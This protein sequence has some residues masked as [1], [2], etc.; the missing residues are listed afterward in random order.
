M[1]G[2]CSVNE[3]SD[4]E[5]P[6]FS[7]QVLNYKF[8]E[9][10]SDI[11]SQSL[12]D[13]ASE[14][15]S[16]GEI[17][18]SLQ[19]MLHNTYNID[20]KANKAP[21]ATKPTSATEGPNFEEYSRGVKAS[22]VDIENNQQL[23]LNSTEQTHLSS[24]HGSISKSLDEYSHFSWWLRRCSIFFIFLAFAA[25]IA[26]PL[27]LRFLVPKQEDSSDIITPPDDPLPVS[28]QAPSATPALLP[29][30][31]PQEDNVSG[32][33]EEPTSIGSESEEPQNSWDDFRWNR[34]EMGETIWRSDL[35]GGSPIW[36]FA[37]AEGD[38][39][40]VSS[41][42]E[43]D[44]VNAA[45]GIYHSYILRAIDDYRASSAVVALNLSTVP[46]ESLCEPVP[47]KI[48]IC[49]GTFGNTDWYGQTILLMKDYSVVAAAIQI[50]T[51]KELSSEILQHTLC[52]QLG[53]ALGLQHSDR[54]SCLQ[55]IGGAVV[56][57]T[58]IS[59]QLQHPSQEDL[60]SLV[61]LYGP[62]IQRR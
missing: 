6:H 12:Q 40:G 42:I 10:E 41:G 1:L 43:L 23:L 46:Y 49:N 30:S 58:A 61:D 56:D 55:D 9:E 14:I 50:N 54:A 7:Y 59:S 26:V 57:E 5:S 20:G 31:I 32:T 37:P 22:E 27:C 35:E 4:L 28:T 25:T 44:I 52:H 19:S 24:T 38:E 34:I 13:Q 45:D 33:T 3:V 18:P 11:H 2:T 60:D 62:A 29:T 16:N 8:S 47:G 17:S 51:S 21:S 39:S 48:K 53:H 36:Y 15:N